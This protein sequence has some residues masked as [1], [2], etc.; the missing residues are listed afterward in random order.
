MVWERRLGNGPQVFCQWCQ[1]L[2][3]HGH[4]RLKI[5]NSLGNSTQRCFLMRP[6]YIDMRPYDFPVALRVSKTHISS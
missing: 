2:L 6:D 1:K 3:A 5:A 4:K